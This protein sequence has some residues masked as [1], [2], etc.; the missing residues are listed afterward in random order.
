MGANSEKEILY[1][2][3]QFGWRDW[4]V[5]NFARTEGVR[6]KLRRKASTLPGVDYMEA[7]EVALCFGWIDGQANSLDENFHLQVF[8][9]RRSRSTWSQTNRDRVAR[10][11]ADGRMQP[12]GIA[13][14]EAAKA[15]GRWD[16]AYARQ[17]ETVVPEDLQQAIDANP[18]A[19][20]MFATLSSQNR[21]A[22]V[23]RTNGVKRAETRAAKIAGFVAML[24]RGETIHPQKPAR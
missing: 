5:T 12:P 24:E 21:F 16:A 10:L 19:S 18:S 14:I 2:S 13:Q 1:F 11:I 20:A 23:F 15:D 6:L 3:D 22:I 8:S 9:P 4:L 17:S 7:L